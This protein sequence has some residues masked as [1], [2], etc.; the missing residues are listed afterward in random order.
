MS[1]H[2]TQALPLEVRLQRR[3]LHAFLLEHTLKAEDDVHRY[4]AALKPTGYD[5]LLA[6]RL[7]VRAVEDLVELGVNKVSR[8][9]RGLGGRLEWVAEQQR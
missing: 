6:L 9:R 8:Q 7:R 1:H 5:N 3:A 2:T 4:L